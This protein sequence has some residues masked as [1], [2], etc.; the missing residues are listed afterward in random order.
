LVICNYFLWEAT[1]MRLRNLAFLAAGIAGFQA[2]RRIKRRQVLPQLAGRNIII[3]GGSRG[4]GLAMVRASLEH[5]AEVTFCS[6]TSADIEA[7]T[8]ILSEEFPGKSFQ[9][10]IYDVR[11][12]QQVREFAEKFRRE[13]RALN[14]LINNA[15]VIEVGPAESMTR[16]DFERSLATHFWGPFQLIDALLPALRESQGH[17]ANIASIG[18]RIS[19]PHLLPYSVGKFALVGYSEG[20]AHELAKDGISVTT[21]CPGLMRTGSARHA[22]FKGDEEAEHA[23]FNL[24]SAL[25]L[26]TISAEEAAQRILIATLKREAVCNFPWTT[27]AAVVAQNFFPKLTNSLLQTIDGFLPGMLSH[28]DDE[29]IRGNHVGT[30]GVPAILT[31]LGEQAAN[32]LNEKAS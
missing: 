30:G 20:L 31:T 18:G 26:I 15:G 22:W 6:R 19:V 32:R 1:P 21:V 28:T 7:A 4:L 29:R 11:D 9:G 13:R 8:E 17:I 12:A 14:L 10:F 3:T 5:D 24:A 23:W 2:L 16:E 27:Q 25:P